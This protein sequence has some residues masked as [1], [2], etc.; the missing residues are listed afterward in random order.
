M[1]GFVIIVAFAR[2]LFPTEAKL[3]MDL[4]IGSNG[5]LKEMDLNETPSAKHKR[6]ISRIESLS[7][8]GT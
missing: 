5:N 6:I 3:A 1:S 2:L 4:A 7:K 8:T